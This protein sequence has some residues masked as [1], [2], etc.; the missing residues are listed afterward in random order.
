[1]KLLV[2][3][4]LIFGMCTKVDAKVYY[5]EYSEFSNYSLEKVES[6]ELI[7]VQVERRNKWYRYVAKGG[8]YKWGENPIFEP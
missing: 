2:G 4:F 3:L 6:S 7:D 8:Y 5:S 1:M